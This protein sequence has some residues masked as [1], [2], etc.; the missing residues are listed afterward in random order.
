MLGAMSAFKS[1]K[2]EVDVDDSFNVGFFR[3]WN[4]LKERQTVRYWLPAFGG[5]LVAC[6]IL[7]ASLQV[8]AKSTENPVFRPS[9]EDAR[10]MHTTTNERPLL[11]IKHSSSKSKP[12]SADAR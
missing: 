6:T 8:V 3:V 10:L 4:V 5:A 7:L 1:L 2:M 9:K 11:L 12:V